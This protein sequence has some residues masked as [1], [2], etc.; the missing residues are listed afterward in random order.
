MELFTKIHNT[1]IIELNYISILKMFMLNHRLIDPPKKPQDFMKS[2]SEFLQ[3]YAKEK[4]VF[5]A[6]SGGVDSSAT[7][8]TLKEAN[9]EIDRRNGCR[10]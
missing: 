9:I 2:A 8:M 3:K 7:Y 4:K 5:C 10:R 6:L 1:L